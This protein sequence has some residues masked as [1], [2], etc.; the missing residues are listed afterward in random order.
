MK[1]ILQQDVA[2]V[3]KEGEVKEVADGYARN[4]LIPKKLALAA[5]AGNLRSLKNEMDAVQ[6]RSD[7]AKQEASDLGTKIQAAS[8]TIKAHV[9]AGTKL[10]GSVTTQDIA[11]A[12]KAQAD[13]DVDKRKI[14]LDE[15][16]RSLG[17][18]SVPVKLQRGLTVK[19]AVEV[20]NAEAPEPAPAPSS[21]KPAEPSP[22]EQA[23][24]ETPDTPSAEEA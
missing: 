19:L 7:R 22:N 10:Y 3:G 20:V 5:T 23:T 13:I 24:D 4:F 6:R 1:V 18:F 14:M 8:V 21:A 17:S 15:P 2:N 16:I 12:L 9:G 11:D